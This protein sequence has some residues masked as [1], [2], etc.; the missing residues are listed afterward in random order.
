M[1][2][3]VFFRSWVN[4]IIFKATV[5]GLNWHP[6]SN[7]K[8]LNRMNYYGEINNRF[9]F[10]LLQTP[11][12]R[13]SINVSNVMLMKF[14]IV[15]CNWVLW[16]VHCC[17]TVIFSTI[18]ISHFDNVGYY[19]SSKNRHK[20]RVKFN[21]SLLILNNSRWLTLIFFLLIRINVL[22]EW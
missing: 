3:F 22:T 7:C 14:W 21:S 20:K 4:A 11:K 12:L 2:T 15:L 1:T 18:S 5:P 6:N 9:K 17:A 16:L 10:F 13:M 19:Y 8:H